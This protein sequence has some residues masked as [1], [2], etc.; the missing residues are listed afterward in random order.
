M[1][2]IVEL[3]TSRR[4]AEVEADSPLE[5]VMVVKRNPDFTH[6]HIEESADVMVDDNGNRQLVVSVNTHRRWD[7]EP[8][9]N[10]PMA[11]NMGNGRI[12]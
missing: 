4:Y 2:Y 10:S 9:S 7:L 1:K 11:E 12:A 3:R 6:T 8:T 5:A